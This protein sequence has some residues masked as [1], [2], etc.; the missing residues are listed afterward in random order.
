MCRLTWHTHSVCALGV[1]TN[2]LASTSCLLSRAMMASAEALGVL[3]LR[4]ARPLP[5]VGMD[6]IDMRGRNHVPFLRTMSAIRLLHEPVSPDS[7]PRR[8]FIPSPPRT[9]VHGLVA[10]TSIGHHIGAVGWHR[11]PRR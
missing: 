5:L 11:K 10:N 9:V 1:E 7:L 4:E 2:Q 8:G 6:M 3:I